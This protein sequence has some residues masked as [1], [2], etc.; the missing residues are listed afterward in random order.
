VIAVVF[1]AETEEEEEVEE[2]EMVGGAKSGATKKCHTSAEEGPRLD[3][4]LQLIVCVIE[5]T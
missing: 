4:T 5:R 3:S 2:V 1:E